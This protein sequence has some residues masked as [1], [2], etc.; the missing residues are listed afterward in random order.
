MFIK[1]VVIILAYMLCYYGAF[2]ISQHGFFSLLCAVG[3]GFLTAQV[4]VS[5]QHDCNHGEDVCHHHSILHITTPPHAQAMGDNPD[6]IDNPD[7][8]LHP[9]AK[10]TCQLNQSIVEVYRRYGMEVER[11][12]QQWRRSICL[13]WLLTPQL[14]AGSGGVIHLQVHMVNGEDWRMC[15]ELLWTW[16]GPA[17]RCWS[18]FFFFW[19]SSVCTKVEKMNLHLQ[20]GKLSA[21]KNQKP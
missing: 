14:T 19:F 1:S 10:K 8:I 3:M 13:T 7:S 20:S 9:D 21:F 4:G 18:F 15:W 5:I 12:W 2:F 6:L 16:W 11:N 17:G